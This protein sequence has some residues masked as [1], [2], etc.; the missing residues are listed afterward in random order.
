LLAPPQRTP[1]DH[2]R[3]EAS[4]VDRLKFIQG[5]KR[6]GLRL[7]EIRDLLAVRDTG[8]CPC[9]SAETLLRQRITDI[10]AEL[11]RLSAL[12]SSLESMVSQIADAADEA[13]ATACPDPAPG[14]WCPPPETTILPE[15]V[16][17]R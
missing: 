5:A 11:A 1:A 10:D 8:R 6:L 2:R 4:A 12:R 15:E 14:S 13:C 16:I 17:R 7:R 9:E 3:Y